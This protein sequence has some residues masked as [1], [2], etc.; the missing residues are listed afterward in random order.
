MNDAYAFGQEAEKR[1]A[2]FYQEQG[3]TVE[4]E[5]F[6]YRKAEI[7]LIVRNQE[8]L[9]AVEVKARSSIAFGAPYSF[10]SC[11]KIKRIVM[12]MDAFVQQRQLDVEIRFDVLSCTYLRGK[13][14]LEQLKDAFCYF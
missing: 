14:H 8:F 12:A 6:R 10:I 7:D 11:K 2:L 3:Y 9:V 13:W 1:A 5:N 4:A